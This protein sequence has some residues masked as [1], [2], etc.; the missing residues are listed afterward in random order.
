MLPLY[1]LGGDQVTE[2]LTIMEHHR[3]RI[4]SK[5]CT[6]D[7]LELGMIPIL[8]LSDVARTVLFSIW[9]G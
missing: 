7:L 1:F 5:L 8:S 4:R 6:C 3:H 9:L 2:T